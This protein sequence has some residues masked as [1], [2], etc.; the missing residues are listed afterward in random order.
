MG[1]EML[2]FFVS[3]IMIGWIGT[4]ALAAFQI[5]NQYYFLIVIPIFSLSQA[6]AILVGHACGAKEFHEVKKLSYASIAMVLI[7]CS[8]VAVIFLAFPKTL[9]SFYIN[10]NDEANAQTYI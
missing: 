9:A 3:G 7:A 6:S 4:V 10:V 8:I 1:G 2:S 5:V